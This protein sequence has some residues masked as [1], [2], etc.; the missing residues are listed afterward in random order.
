M[1]VS[2]LCAFYVLHMCNNII[3]V[4]SITI[5]SYICHLIMVKY[6]VYFF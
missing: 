6:L 1:C 5:T 4:L 2:S 3:R